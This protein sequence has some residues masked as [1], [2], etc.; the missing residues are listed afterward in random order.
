MKTYFLIATTWALCLCSACRTCEKPPQPYPCKVIKG[1]EGVFLE[2]INS[3]Q[4]FYVCNAEKL[5][6]Y[7]HDARVNATFQSSA[8]DDPKTSGITSMDYQNAVEI[9]HVD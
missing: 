5:S 9:L 8:C 3:A 4:R 6:A 1:R 7:A 2:N